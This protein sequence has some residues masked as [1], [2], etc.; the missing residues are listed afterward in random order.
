MDRS[1][2]IAESDAHVMHEDR[3]ILESILAQNR[4]AVLDLH[5]LLASADNSYQASTTPEDPSKAGEHYKRLSESTGVRTLTVPDVLPPSIGADMAR[6]IASGKDD[7]ADPLRHTFSKRGVQLGV[8]MSILDLNA[9]EA[10]EELKKKWIQ[11]ARDKS[12][13]IHADKPPPTFQADSYPTAFHELGKI[14]EVDSTSNIALGIAQS[15]PQSH[16]VPS[17]EFIELSLI[18][19]NTP[20][21]K[22]SCPPNT[23]D[24]HATDSG[25]ENT[26]SR[27]KQAMR[28]LSKPSLR[29]SP[30]IRS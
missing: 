16:T 28:R 19:T 13:S 23:P 17:S 1:D 20:N 6:P 26:G 4:N 9:H 11:E 10:S 15:P 22:P 7:I 2:R 29:P 12:S 25:G 24:E 3:V 18:D 21:R 8:H 30:K 27:L 14:S 5:N